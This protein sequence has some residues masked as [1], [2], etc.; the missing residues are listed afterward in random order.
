MPDSLHKQM[1][2]ARQRSI[3][4]SHAVVRKRQDLHSV[5]SDFRKTVIALR[6]ITEA[7]PDTQA[8]WRNGSD[9]NTIT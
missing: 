2:I 5:V 8:V 1:E 4:D 3:G 6:Q 7:F 9:G